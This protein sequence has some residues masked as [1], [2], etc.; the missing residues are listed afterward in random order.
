MKATL[1]FDGNEERES[2]EDAIHGGE[3][4]SVVWDIDQLLRSC[5][6]HGHSYQSADEALEKVR[7]QLREEVNSRGLQLL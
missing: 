5:L 2:L 3:W 7:D 4:K 1:E 6:K